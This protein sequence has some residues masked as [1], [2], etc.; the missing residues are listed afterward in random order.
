MKSSTAVPQR[1]ASQ[2]SLLCGLHPERV[3]APIHVAA[4]YR[5]SREPRS[6]WTAIRSVCRSSRSSCEVVASEWRRPSSPDSCSPCWCLKVTPRTGLRAVPVRTGSTRSAVPCLREESGDTFT[7]MC[8]L[9][10]SERP[11]L[12]CE[13]YGLSALGVR[14]TARR[15]ALPDELSNFG[16]EL[17]HWTDTL[18]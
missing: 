14:I 17:V 13:P 2:I 16:A 3:T 18:P 11:G 5:G 4:P 15:R 6:H 9:R 12:R 1:A 10:K 7:R 8:E